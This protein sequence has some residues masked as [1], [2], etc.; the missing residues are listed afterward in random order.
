MLFALGVGDQVLAVTH[1]CDYPPEAAGRRHL[2]RSLV[3]AGLSAKEIDAEV[4]RL[5][6]E[7]RHLYELN[8]ST[9]QELDVDL[10]VTQAV[11]EVCAVSYDDVVAVAARL[12]T[13]PRVISLDPSNLAE[14]L[15]DVPRLGE[16]TG[17][18]EKAIALRSDLEQRL[19]R[20][21]VA[22][23]GASR[24]RV[25]AIEWLDPPFIGGHWV[26]EMI[27]ISG[28]TDVL[29]VPGA[30]SRTAEWDELAAS[31]PDVIVA[32]PCGW[33]A[34]RARAEVEIRATE[35]AAIGAERIWAVDAAASFSR[36]GPRLVEG[37]ELIAH[38]LHPDRVD[39]PHGVT[40]EPAP[41]PAPAGRS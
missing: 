27:E 4:R 10:I 9:L 39:A 7:G 30:K 22:V 18:A 25:L 40:F 3:P 6:G 36:P 15:A 34:T 38:L 20:V 28:G 23:E 1:E 14:V 13:R 17:V 31:A 35:V 12:P 16:A 24:P 21:R 29:G 11:C 41:L 32:M 37:T 5:T 33:D 2:T 19:E 26:P 8:E